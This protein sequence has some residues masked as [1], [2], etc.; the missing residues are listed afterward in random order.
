MKK[1]LSVV[2][3]LIM[4]LVSSCMFRISESVDYDE[5][6]H[7]LKRTW[8][9]LKTDYNQSE[10]ADQ[11]TIMSLNTIGQG[12]NTYI[13]M[14]MEFMEIID[15]SSEKEVNML[16]TDFRNAVDL[17]SIFEGIFSEALFMLEEGKKGVIPEIIPENPEGENVRKEIV[18]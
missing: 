5:A 12:I 14:I 7:E 3:F 11:M 4:F 16:Q 17:M 13:V 10:V 1:R 8:I 15:Y 2:L 6:L 18:I 9:L